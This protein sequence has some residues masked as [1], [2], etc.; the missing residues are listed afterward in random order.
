MHNQAKVGS[1]VSQGGRTSSEEIL[2][3]RMSMKL[4]CSPLNEVIAEIGFCRKAEEHA[5]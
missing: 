5:P 3:G 4:V 2:P 1:D